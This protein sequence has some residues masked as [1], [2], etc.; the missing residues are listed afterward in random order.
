MDNK[1]FSVHNPIWRQNSLSQIP[2]WLQNTFTKS[3][4]ILTILVRKFKLYYLPINQYSALTS[5]TLNGYFL[6]YFLEQAISE[7]QIWAEK[8]KLFLMVKK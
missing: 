2:F 8:F 4:R 7:A 3:L 1:N 5:E 6:Q